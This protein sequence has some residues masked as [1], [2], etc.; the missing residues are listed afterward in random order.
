[1]NTKQALISLIFCFP[2]FL[3]SCQEDPKK[4]AEQLA[5]TWCDC[6]KDLVPLYESLEQAE[7]PQQRTTAL[8]S[9]HLVA[10][11]NMECLGGEK[12]WEEKDRQMTDNQ[13]D[14]FLKTFRRSKEEAC[15]D[16]FR[17]ISELEKDIKH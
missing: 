9:M 10:A 13:K 8:D 11:Q 4:L 3:L 5:Q 6:N 17:V 12:K 7:S 14:L 1:M 15:P 16:I 2:L